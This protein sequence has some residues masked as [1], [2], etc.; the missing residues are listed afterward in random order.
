MVTSLRDRITAAG[1]L[2]TAFCMDSWLNIV[3]HRSIG[4]LNLGLAGIRELE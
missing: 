1:T 3:L 4:R 2:V